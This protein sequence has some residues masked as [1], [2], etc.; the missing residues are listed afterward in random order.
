MRFAV[1]G[2]RLEERI[3]QLRRDAVAFVLHLDLQFLA[4]LFETQHDRAALLHLPRRS[5]PQR[6]AWRRRLDDRLHAA[7]RELRTHSLRGRIQVRREAQRLQLGFASDC[8]GRL[9]LLRWNQIVA[10]I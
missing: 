4:G 5:D 7:L 6:D 1:R 9:P 3:R 8:T 2:E 10:R